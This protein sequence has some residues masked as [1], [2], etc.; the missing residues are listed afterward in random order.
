M[1]EFKAP[2][3]LMILIPA[4][5]ISPDCDDFID[6]FNVPTPISPLPPTPVASSSHEQ[7]QDAIYDSLPPMEQSTVPK[8]PLKEPM[9]PS[10][11]PE[12]PL[13]GPVDSKPPI[14]SKLPDP[15]VK[16]AHVKNVDSV[17]HR[18]P[19]SRESRNEERRNKERRN[20]ERRPRDPRMYRRPDFRPPYR[21]HDFKPRVFRGPP[22]A[23]H[24][25]PTSQEN[26]QVFFQSQGLAVLCIRNSGFTLT[27]RGVSYAMDR[28]CPN[29]LFK[30][31]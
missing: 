17:I 31:L 28:E 11:V 25:M 24:L 13:K 14:V 26:A 23:Q 6:M 19:R 2:T 10:R 7:S 8:S 15:P 16:K 9:E 22:Y 29:E 27:N 1:V 3:H 21:R 18:S 5:I 20:E 4:K 30:F 12:S